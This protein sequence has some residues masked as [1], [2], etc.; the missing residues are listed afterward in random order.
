MESIS[1]F[2][3][4]AKFAYF[5]CK[6][7][8]VPSFIIVEYVTDFRAGAFLPASPPSHH[9]AAPRRPILNILNRVQAIIFICF[10]C[11]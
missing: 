7:A 9:Q 11:C 6:N 1:V 2:L 3:D 4:I 10:I 8:D 5:R